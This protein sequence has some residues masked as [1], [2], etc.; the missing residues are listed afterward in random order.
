[1]NDSSFKLESTSVDGTDEI[2]T[3]ITKPSTLDSRL[4]FSTSGKFTNRYEEEI[5][6]LKRECKKY[7]TMAKRLMFELRVEGLR[8]N[9]S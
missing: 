6:K 8:R 3:N 1:M 9:C 4:K 5:R 2:V 7:E